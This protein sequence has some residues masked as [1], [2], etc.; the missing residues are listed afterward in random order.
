MSFSLFRFG[1]SVDGKL[2][3]ASIAWPNE[4][5]LLIGSLL[6]TVGAGLQSLTGAPRLMQAIA[7]DNLIPCLSFFGV[8]SSRGEPLR[9]LILTAGKH[10]Y[11]HIAKD[12]FDQ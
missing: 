10:N 4:W 2:C 3:I 8:S 11:K 7:S 1:Q 9:A 12:H 6:S 5:V